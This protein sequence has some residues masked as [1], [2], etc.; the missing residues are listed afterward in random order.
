[1]LRSLLVTALTV[2]LLSCGGPTAS[3]RGTAQD[4]SVTPE[5]RPNIVVIVVDD[6]RFDDVLTISTGNLYFFRLLFGT[7]ISTSA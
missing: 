5:E 7:S 3:P 1:M 6:L 2:T 4:Y